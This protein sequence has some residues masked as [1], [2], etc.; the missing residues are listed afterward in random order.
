MKRITINLEIYQTKLIVLVGNESEIIEY[1][2]KKNDRLLNKV[3]DRLKSSSM[4]GFT[5]KYIK[6]LDAFVVGIE[7]DHCKGYSVES[8]LAHELFHAVDFI[9]TSRDIEL[10]GEPGSYLMGYLMDKS[11]KGINKKEKK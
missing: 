2:S 1:L 10:S 3:V 5:L 7:L 8:I 4:K 6:A 9:L 11:I